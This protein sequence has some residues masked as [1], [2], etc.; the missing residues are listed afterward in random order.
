[1]KS[2]IVEHISDKI[3]AIFA[4]LPS[5]CDKSFFGLPPWYKYLDM[6]YDSEA[7]SCVVRDFQLL[8]NGTDSGLLLIALAIVDMLLRIAGVVAVAF[9]LWGGFSYITSQAEP[10][11]LAQAR[12]TIINALIG[13][14][15]ALIATSLVV[16]VGNRLSQ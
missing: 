5:Q 4:A 12:S 16:F 7:Q 14:G 6:R 15:I 10:D 3:P 2:W 8:G 1:M 13:L 11:K 9:V